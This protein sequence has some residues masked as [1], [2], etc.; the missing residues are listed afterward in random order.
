[1]R[2]WPVPDSL[3]KSVPV[4]EQPGSFWEDRGDRRHAG[5]DIFAPTDAEVVAL[6]GG[7]VLTVGCFTCPATNPY[8]NETLEI[9]IE[10]S[11]GIFHRYAELSQVFVAAGQKVE[12]GE[13][14]GT[15]GCVI[16]PT[17]LTAEAPA[18]IRRLIAA[19]NLSMLHFE[20]YSQLPPLAAAY[21]GGNFFVPIPPAGLID[22]T[23]VLSSLLVGENTN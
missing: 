18:H 22:P 11:N 15:V 4:A 19:Q 8:W 17:G 1:M 6:E 9:L 20:I 14:I 2:F 10:T 13:K 12:P 23:P 5:V 16:N 3:H 21:S 7:V